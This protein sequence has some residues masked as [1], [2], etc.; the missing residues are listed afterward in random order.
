M[1][2][3]LFFETI[4]KSDNLR[5]KLCLKFQKKTVK[6]F[7]VSFQSI[8][9]P[10]KVLGGFDNIFHVYFLLDKKLNSHGGFLRAD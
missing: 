6:L 8:E 10:K 7:T 2:R 9:I 4:Q 3:L 5:R 1:V